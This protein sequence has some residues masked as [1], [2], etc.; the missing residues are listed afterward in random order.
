MDIYS[1]ETLF[2]ELNDSISSES[3]TF[4]VRNDDLT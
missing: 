2:G 3:P 1:W 4:S